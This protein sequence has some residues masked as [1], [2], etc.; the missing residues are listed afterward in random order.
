MFA[1]RLAGLLV[2]LFLLGAATVTHEAATSSS[3]AGRDTAD[4][5]R[6]PLTPVLTSNGT[7]RRPAAMRPTARP[8]KAPVM[9]VIVNVSSQRELVQAISNG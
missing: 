5:G 3:S 2:G 9:D 4:R 8:T 6:S 7:P 1:C